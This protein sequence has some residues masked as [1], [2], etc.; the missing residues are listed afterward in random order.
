MGEVREFPPSPLP[1]PE[2][3]GEKRS[4]SSHRTR[5]Q[6]EGEK[7]GNLPLTQRRKHFCN[8]HGTGVGDP[9]EILTVHV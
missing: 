1:S 2:G 8:R 5:S 4:F 3:E 6:G 9:F 7:R